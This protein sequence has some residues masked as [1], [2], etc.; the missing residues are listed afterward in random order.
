MNSLAKSSVDEIRDRF[1]REVERF[2]NLSTGQTATIDAAECMNLVATAAA[3]VTP[4][5]SAVL[6]VGC[7]AGNYSL[8]L[9]ERAP[10]AAFTL[11]DLSEPMLTRARERLSPSPT[12]LI[13]RDVRDLDWAQPQFDVILAAAVLHHLRTSAE[14]A[15]TFQKF[16]R[17]LKPGGSVWIFDLVSHENEAVQAMMW[18]KYG[19]YLDTLGGASYRDKVF[20]Y[21]DREDTPAPL[22]SQLGWLREAGFE[23]I[24]VLHKN[25]SFA[26]FGAVK[27]VP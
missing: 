11:V 24:D 23:K 15:S 17:W 13:Q 9:R 21:I 18:D 12:T 2:S 19:Q 10:A 14:W 20:A 7:G 27:T 6:D 5:V 26:A 1:D 22:T 8:K 3:A 16:Y 25:A 4:N